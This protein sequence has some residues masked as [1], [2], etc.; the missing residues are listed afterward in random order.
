M[1]DVA[2]IGRGSFLGENE[3]VLIRNRMVLIAEM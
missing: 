1:F 3:S 2:L